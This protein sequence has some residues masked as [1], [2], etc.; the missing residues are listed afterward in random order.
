VAIGRLAEFYE[1]NIDTKAL[2]LIPVPV[3]VLGGQVPNPGKRFHID[4]EC[5]EVPTMLDFIKANA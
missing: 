3:G 2:Q 4:R 5:G 1:F